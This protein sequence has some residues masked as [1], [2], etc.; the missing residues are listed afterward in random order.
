MPLHQQPYWADRILT[1]VYETSGLTHETIDNLLAIIDTSDQ[2][3]M[4]KS[5]FSTIRR[6][7]LTLSE[8]RKRGCF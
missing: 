6:Y 4:A 2:W 5:Q 1:L 7:F 8:K 3:K